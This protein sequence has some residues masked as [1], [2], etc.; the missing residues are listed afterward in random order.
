VGGAL[1]TGLV[2]RLGFGLLGV[3]VVIGAW[4]GVHALH[5]VATDT[6]PAPT[7]VLERIGGLLAN[8]D[9]RSQTADTLWTWLV[10]MALTAAITVPLGIV[11]GTAA[12]LYRPTVTVVHAMRSVPAT[13][14]IPVSVLLF[15][16]G[17]SMKLALTVFAIFGPMLLNTIYGVHNTEPHLLTV[18]RS[19]RWSR[20][21]TLR[22]VVLPSALPS[23]VT[24]VRVASGIALIVI[25]SVELL[26]ASRGIGT[27]IVKYQEIP[28]PDF[29]YAGIILTGVLGLIL[30]SALLAVERRALPWTHRSTGD[31]GG[32]S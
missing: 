15:G 7:T 2:S 31:A 27:I 1:P 25:V 10:S 3:V 16:L 12:A 11:L 32:R 5:L 21:Q 22:R 6:L 18:A 9:F 29:V 28:R 26:G 23:I 24:G 19:M 14:F 17:L 4:A 13:V 8:A 20:A 30:Y